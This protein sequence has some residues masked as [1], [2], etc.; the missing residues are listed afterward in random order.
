[1]A[2]KNDDPKVINPKG[3]GEKHTPNTSEISRPHTSD[4][5]PEKHVDSIAFGKDGKHEP[6]HDVN[7][8]TDP[9]LIKM[10]QE[11][12]DKHQADKK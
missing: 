7:H 1:M 3:E 12:H 5:E 6:E 8:I 2:Q 9:D 10:G 4:A 11:T